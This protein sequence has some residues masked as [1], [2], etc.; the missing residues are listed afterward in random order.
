MQ[1]TQKKVALWVHEQQYNIKRWVK[2]R[3]LL[4]FYELYL[5]AVNL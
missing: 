4:Y 1:K 3:D 5:T 2:R